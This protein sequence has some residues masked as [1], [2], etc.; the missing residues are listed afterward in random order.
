MPELKSTVK[1]QGY[2]CRYSQITG[3]LLNFP[4]ITQK[5]HIQFQVLLYLE[6]SIT[7]SPYGGCKLNIHLF[8]L[9]HTFAKADFSRFS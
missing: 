7:E 6:I 4:H 2:Y 8:S 5:V 1:S 3:S 9:F